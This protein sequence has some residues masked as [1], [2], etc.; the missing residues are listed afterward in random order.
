MIERSRFNTLLLSSMLLACLPAIAWTKAHA[1]PAGQPPEDALVRD[2]V[3]AKVSTLADP[4]QQYSLYLPPEHVPDEALPLLIILD[5]RGRGE[6]TLRMALEGARANGWIVMSSW[7]SRSDTLE[8]ITLHALQALLD[9]A[10]RR[11]HYDSRRLY[12]AGFSG[13][14]KTLWTQVEALQG[15]L[16]GMIG[17]GGG[18]PPELGPL[19]VAPPAFFGITGTRDFNYQEMRDLD[20]ALSETGAVHRL[21]VFEGGHGWP[22][23]PSMFTAA[24]DWLQLMAMRDGREGKRA[25]WI[26]AQLA[27]ARASV[28][29][30][31][32]PLERWRRTDQLARDFDGLRD[33]AADK[34]AATQLAASRAVRKALSLKHNL[35]S[36]ERQHG[37]RFDAWRMHAGARDLQGRRQDPP[38]VAHAVAELRIRRLQEQAG[39]GDQARA[40]S[41]ARVLER[42]Y[43]ATAFYLPEQLAAQGDV[44]RAIAM[45]AIASAI[46]P[47]R[48]RPHWRRAQLLASDQR[49]DDAFE[50]LAA[51]RKLGYADPDDLRSNPV[52]QPL[53]AD[54]RWVATLARMTT[55][56]TQPRADQ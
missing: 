25:D 18:R 55:P 54:P 2:Q 20:D 34:S 7:Q 4:Q 6:S 3:I 44:Q 15:P 24:I 10:A 41:A 48:P 12:L 27:A 51:S 35:R 28:N 46:F 42:E 36:N 50:A 52:W 56:V 45:L 21:A 16:A 30:T 53:R 19:R 17:C 31:P 38:S 47:A 13:T 1:D 49:I 40:D 29:E 8:S 43:V 32:D 22:P 14:A 37:K 33:V 23:D 39:G 26:D 9:E 11:F 5:A